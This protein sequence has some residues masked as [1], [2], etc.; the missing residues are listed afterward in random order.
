MDTAY[1]LR[2]MLPLVASRYKSCSYTIC[3]FPKAGNHGSHMGKGWPSQTEDPIMYEWD[4]TRKS[5][6]PLEGP[7]GVHRLLA[8]GLRQQGIYDPAACFGHWIGRRS[9][10]ISCDPPQIAARTEGNRLHRN[11]PSPVANVRFE[12]GFRHEWWKAERRYS[13]AEA[14]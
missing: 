12:L 6:T 13:P 7:S 3:T 11:F 2:P 4:E 10:T 1:A 14:G 9:S 8:P 5:P